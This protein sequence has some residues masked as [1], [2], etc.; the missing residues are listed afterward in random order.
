MPAP[1]H[2]LPRHHASPCQGQTTPLENVNQ[3]SL[4]KACPDRGFV[5]V[6]WDVTNTPRLLLWCWFLYIRVHVCA[7]NK[8]RVILY[9][10]STYPSPLGIRCQH[11]SAWITSC[12]SDCFAFLGHFPI[13]ESL[14]IFLPSPTVMH[15]SSL[16]HGPW[17]TAL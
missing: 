11:L 17:L 14:R 15:R 2:G 12:N 8:N 1:D 10:L 7:F 4:L 3:K 16:S 13:C 6:V 5:T 9:S